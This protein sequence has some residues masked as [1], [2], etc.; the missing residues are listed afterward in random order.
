MQTTFKHCKNRRA[1]P[2]VH[3]LNNIAADNKIF[4]TGV[5]LING[6]LFQVHSCPQCLQCCLILIKMPIC[7]VNSASQYW[8]RDLQAMN[9]LSRWDLYTRNLTS[10]WWCDSWVS[11]LC[12]ITGVNT[13][14]IPFVAA[15][16]LTQLCSL[17]DFSRLIHPSLFQFQWQWSH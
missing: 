2:A 9:R 3:C 7:W 11:S 16:M 6:W 13:L 4:P 12:D 10:S 5:F 15:C 1:F 14:I 17:H 8:W